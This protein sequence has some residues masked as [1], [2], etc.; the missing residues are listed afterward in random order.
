MVLRRVPSV[1]EGLIGKFT[2]QEEEPHSKQDGQHYFTMPSRWTQAMIRAEIA[3]EIIRLVPSWYQAKC[4]PQRYLLKIADHEEPF[5]HHSTLSPS[6]ETFLAKLHLAM[7]DVD[8]QRLHVSPG[9]LDILLE[10][11]AVEWLRIHSPTTDWTRLI[12]YLEQ[13]SRRTTRQNPYP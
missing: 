12:D 11:L 3:S 2:W 5:F 7:K 4:G 8:P 9:L 10:S 1:H 13:V 6:L